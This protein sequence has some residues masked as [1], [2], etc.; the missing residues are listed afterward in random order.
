MKIDSKDRDV[1]D[2]LAS[3]FYKV[4]RFQ[5]PYRWEKDNVI[6][7]W[8]DT[9]MD[10]KGDYFIGAMVGYKLKENFFGIV[11][12][13]QRIQRTRRAGKRRYH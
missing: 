9:I 5:R 2:I 7:F 1:Q 4:P 8:Q 3:S 12:G 10:S 11:D 13:Q 6:D